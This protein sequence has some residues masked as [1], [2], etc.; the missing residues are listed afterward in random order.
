MP[1]VP[2]SAVVLAYDDQWLRD[3]EVLR[4]HLEP[5]LAGVDAVVEHVGST[6]VPGL[7]AKPV[8]DVDVVV[9]GRRTYPPPSRRW[10]EPV[11][12]IR[13]TSVSAA[14]RRSAPCRGCRSTTCT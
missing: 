14:G 3:F 13:V 5:A 10:S 12:G 8:I 11:G 1:P 2:R 6:A 4:G 9:A 7:A